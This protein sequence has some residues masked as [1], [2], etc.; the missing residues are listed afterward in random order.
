MELRCMVQ[1]YDWGKKG[2]HSS[3]AKLFKSSNCDVEINE[4]KSY[5]E[6]WMGTHVNGPSFIKTC[7]S[8]LGDHISKNKTILGNEVIELFG[9]TLP[10][11]FKV[12]SVGKALSIQAHPDK[13]LAENLHRIHPQIYKDSN[14]KPELAIALTEFQALCGFRPVA[15][16]QYFLKIIPELCFVIGENI[17][18][19]FI[20]SDEANSREHL[21]KCL[22]G[23]LTHQVDSA[24]KQLKFF[25]ERLAQMGKN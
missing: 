23:L 5:A 14:H 9:E 4:N 25:L 17:A 2:M 24:A 22:Q 21:Q 20:A 12:L 1:N 7:N 15:E 19:D 16:I 3:V 13:K 18:G 6:L 11:L 8:H 10:F